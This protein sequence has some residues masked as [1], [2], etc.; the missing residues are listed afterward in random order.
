MRSFQCQE[1][2][3]STLSALIGTKMYHDCVSFGSWWDC[4]S[5]LSSESGSVTA[6]SIKKVNG[7]TNG[8]MCKWVSS[9]ITV[10]HFLPSPSL[11]VSL[12]QRVALWDN[13]PSCSLFHSEP[14]E[15]LRHR[16]QPSGSKQEDNTKNEKLRKFNELYSVQ[17]FNIWLDFCEFSQTDRFNVVK[18]K[19]KE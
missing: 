12:R 9:N 1:S 19:S 14:P 18:F 7:L 4:E 2:C 8:E 11:C 6:G 3:N 10:L 15:M 17:L 13:L 16:H 5:M